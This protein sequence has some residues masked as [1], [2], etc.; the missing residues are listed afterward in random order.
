MRYFKN[1]DRTGHID[2]LCRFR[3]GF[4][5]Y[6]GEA[7]GPD[8]R[9]VLCYLFRNVIAL[10]RPGARLLDW[11]PGDEDLFRSD[12]RVYLLL[13]TTETRDLYSQ[14]QRL[15]ELC[16]REGLSVDR[17]IFSPNDY[18]QLGRA[19]GGMPRVVSYDWQLVVKKHRYQMREH[20][21]LTRK[22]KDRRLISL[23]RRHNVERYLTSCYLWRRFSEKVFLSYVFSRKGEDW[24]SLRQRIVRSPF[25][26]FKQPHWLEAASKF[27]RRL[28][29][30]LDRPV[31]RQVGKRI[32]NDVEWNVFNEKGL[33]DELS[34][35]I[36][37]SYFMLVFET[38]AESLAS[39]V[40]QI[41]EK[42]Y[43]PMMYG[44]PF[45]VWTVSGGILRH[46]RKMGFR[47]FGRVIS[48]SYDDDRL[49]YR[50]RYQRLLALIDRICLCSKEEIEGIYRDCLPMVRHNRRELNSDRLP[51]LELRLK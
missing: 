42:T 38:N 41:S 9:L 26:R 14:R 31:K 7:L 51:D 11:Q 2:G 4:Q 19:H 8:D 50:D 17:V 44:I 5:L 28:P 48:E 34:G 20:P 46:L 33:N 3:D 45:I 40:R 30:Y 16:A 39:Q 37:R 12:T 1:A 49:S 18:H 6:G 43:K 32:V 35:F 36:G 23:N 15:R 29:L 22:A 24:R 27:Y 47:T 13:Y 21:D 10:A 25:G